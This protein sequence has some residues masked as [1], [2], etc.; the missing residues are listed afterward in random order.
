M[1]GLKPAGTELTPK[2]AAFYY[3][4]VCSFWR[5][6]PPNGGL[7][8]F[9]AMREAPRRSNLAQFFLNVGYEFSVAHARCDLVEK[10]G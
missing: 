10:F 8:V 5:L 1:S 9:C 4:P 6:W 2:N 7:N 3:W